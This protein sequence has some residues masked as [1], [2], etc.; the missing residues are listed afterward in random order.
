METSSPE[1]WRRIAEYPNYWVSSC[2]RVRHNRKLIKT[3]YSELTGHITVALHGSR[4]VNRPVARIMLEAFAGPCPAQMYASYRDGDKTNL[5][6][7]NLEWNRRRQKTN[8][9]K[10]TKSEVTSILE[11]FKDGV[12]RGKI[13]QAHNINYWAVSYQLR[14]AGLAP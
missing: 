9:R 2:G 3:S 8:R 13:A 7:S 5:N 11:M 12:P 6:L 10:L 14:R 4:T 1:E